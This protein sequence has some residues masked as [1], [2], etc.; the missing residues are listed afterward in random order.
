MPLPAPLQALTK[1]NQ[2]VAV[3]LIPDEAKPGKFKKLPINPHTLMA[4][5]STDPA[6]W[7]TFEQASALGL[8]LGFVLTANDP[9][10]CLDIDGALQSDNTWSPLANE[11]MA[12][13]PGAAVEVSTSGKG[14]HIW[15]TAS[16]PAHKCK[17]IGLGIEL[18]H[19]ERF[20]AFGR[21]DAIGD[22]WQDFGP[23]L[24]GVVAQ[25]FPIVTLTGDEG[26][27]EWI[28]GPCEEWRGSTDDQDLLRRARKSESAAGVFGGGT[29]EDLW[30]GNAER[31]ALRYPDTTGEAYDRSS[32]DRAL[33]QHLAFWTG[34]DCARIERLMRQ[35][36]LVR[37]K[38]ESLRGDHTYLRLTI[39]T[40]V[41]D[42]RTV[43][44]DAK[45]PTMELIAQGAQQP[46][47]GI[48][49]NITPVGVV[50]A[51]AAFVHPHEMQDVFKGCVYLEKLDRA[52]VPGKTEPVKSAAFKV[53][54][55]GNLFVIDDMSGKTISDAWE[56]WTQCQTYRP[57]HASGT[58]FRPDLPHGDLVDNQGEW[59]VNTY[60]PADV[61]CVPGSVDLFLDHMRRLLPD[62]R[63]R[64]ILLA[65]MAAV[66]QYPGIKFA[67]APVIQGTPGNGK[68]L[69]STVLSEAVGRKYT[70]SPTKKQLDKEFNSWMADKILV[71]I[72]DI[73]VR[74]DLLEEFKTIIT[75][76]VASIE[77]KGVDAEMRDVCCN[78]I[79]NCNPKDGVPKTSDD[80]R[81]APFFT[82][83]Q[84]PEDLARDGMT[85]SYFM[86]LYGWLK[87]GGYAAI[88]HFLRTYEIPDSLNPTTECQRA[89]DTSST[90]EA[91]TVGRGAI[92][93][94]ILEAIEEGREGFR[95]GFVSSTYL[96]KLIESGR[97]N[98]ALSRRRALMESL[99]WIYHPSLVEG[100]V[101]NTVHPDGAKP[102]LYVH[103]NDS[104]LLALSTAA[105][106]AR[107][108]SDAQL[109]MT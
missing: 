82:A 25:Y 11:L 47:A 103:R 76:K 13:F 75:G 27:G 45:P 87:Q 71:T 98:V 8:P 85:G 6:T 20:I 58:C 52:F 38:W 40:A 44:V 41:R 69:L 49:T 37:D 66:V 102:R 77:M 95:G 28:E 73:T 106:V 89:P 93:Q 79:F 19:K 2:F 3:K 62:Q 72:E 35:S 100:R 63:D 42:C 39:T 105:D 32:A 16:A 24:Q 31:L 9:F 108:Y 55:G 23:H 26:E 17:N 88:T 57:P 70:V 78:F 43:C 4:A 60:L 10:F 5:S 65:Y 18:Y 59:Y 33:A 34:R 94:E 51:G 56:A 21:P 92:E 96:G 48:A 30:T 12:A 97:R 50:R 109:A 22:A 81:Y 83:Q 104:R 91:I 101:N 107:T 36:A 1:Y 53:K 15:G 90:R 80:R 61:A 29:F 74:R 7:G 46:I 99:G 68:T 54:F 84:S 67:W 64:D 14:L 86:R